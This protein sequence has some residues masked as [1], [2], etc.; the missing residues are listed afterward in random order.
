MDPILLI[1]L[2]EGLDFI[3]IIHNVAEDL[4]NPIPHYENRRR[5]AKPRNEN[6]FEVTI[7]RYTDIQFLEHFRS[8]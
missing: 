2:D 6:Y 3:N 5:N 4:V 8:I 1:A 7:L